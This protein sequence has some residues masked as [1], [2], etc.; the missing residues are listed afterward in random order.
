M[1]KSGESGLIIARH[2]ECLA[3][4]EKRIVGHKESPLTEKGLVQAHEIG[5]KLK[6]KKIDTIVSSPLSRAL[7]T[8]QIVAQYTES[9]EILIIPELKPQSFGVLEG[10][11]REEAVEAGLSDFL[12][13]PETDKYTH[14]VP[15][16][17]TAQQSMERILPVYRLL[18][19]LA[20]DENLSMLLI[21]HN[22]VIRAIA[23]GVWQTRPEDWVS[24][25]VP[26]CEIFKIVQEQPFAFQSIFLKTMAES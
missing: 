5:Q 26:N 17:E 2:G 10:H 21:L 9:Q 8:A 13:K 16:G 15:N 22:S 18:E 19:Q 14:F 7:E 25:T 11:T 1:K 6:Q 12:H 23:G 3:N 24:L 20:D 4:V